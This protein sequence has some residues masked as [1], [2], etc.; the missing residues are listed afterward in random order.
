M[1]TSEATKRPVVTLAGED[2]A[3]VKDVVY[4]AGG[5]AVGG[6]TLAGRGGSPVPRGWRCLGPRSWPSVRTR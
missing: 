1:R 2:V 5:G 3:Q 6:F 4:A